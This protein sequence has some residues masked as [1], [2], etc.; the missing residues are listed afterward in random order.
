MDKVIKVVPLLQTT[1]EKGTYYIAYVLGRV[2]DISVTMETSNITGTFFFQFLDTSGNVVH[3][4]NANRASIYNRVYAKLIGL[5][6]T[7]ENAEVAANSATDDIYRAILSG[8][9]QQK[10]EAMGRFA[11]SYGMTLLPIEQQDGIINLNQ[12]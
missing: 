5:G 3:S 6:Q 1:I 11:A 9:A 12:E 4:V 2:S 10:Y 8:N 7:P